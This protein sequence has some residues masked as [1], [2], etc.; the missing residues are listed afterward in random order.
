[1]L[2]SLSYL[3]WIVFPSLQLLIYFFFL[4]PNQ[5]LFPCLLFLSVLRLHILNPPICFE[6]A[7]FFFFLFMCVVVTR[8]S[9]FRLRWPLNE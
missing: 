4:T 2:K 8:L 3:C 1:M 7:L 6:K 9:R 5:K